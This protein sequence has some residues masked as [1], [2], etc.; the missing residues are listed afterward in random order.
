MHCITEFMRYGVRVKEIMRRNPLAVR[1]E[2]TVYRTIKRIL[3]KKVSSAVVTDKKRHVLGIITEGDMLNKIVLQ[4]KNPMKI[5][6]SQ[7]MT[8]NVITEGPDVDLYKISRLMTKHKIKKIPIIEDGKLI[9]I[10]TET[11]LS[12]FQPS[13]IDVL[14]EKLK[15]KEPSFKFSFWEK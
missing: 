12:T 15:I 11:D 7:V 5:S 10:I 4:R 14:I 2:E 1:P 3:A 9:G 13:L 6:V 8:R